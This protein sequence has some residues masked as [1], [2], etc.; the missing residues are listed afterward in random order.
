MA[1]SKKK[2]PKKTSGATRLSMK[3]AKKQTKKRVSKKTEVKTKKASKKTKPASNK[4]S[5]QTKKKSTQNKK[6]RSDT[7][8]KVVRAPEGERFWTR[9]GH[10]I[11]DIL[12][13]HDI[14]GQISDELFA[15][16]A[17]GG[18]NHFASWVKIVLKDT[19]C[20]ENLKKVRTRS[21]AIKKVKTAT[22]KYKGV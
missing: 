11:A 21:G 5:T 2:Q 6:A 16:H 14:L 7:K 12:E 9:E 8:K 13:L 20:A 19:E 22:K 17:L 15:Y 3:T 10:I 1:T 18:S 4:K